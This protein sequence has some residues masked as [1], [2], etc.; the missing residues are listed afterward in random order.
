MLKHIAFPVENTGFASKTYVLLTENSGFGSKTYVFLRK[1]I[2]FVCPKTRKSYNPIFLKL[3]GRSCRPAG[4]H[5]GRSGEKAKEI[6]KDMVLGFYGFRVVGLGFEVE[7]LWFEGF[8]FWVLGVGSWGLTCKV[9]TGCG[10]G[11][12]RFQS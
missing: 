2:A 10:L 12:L 6:Q 1:T 4:R 7:G 11:L 8:G 5:P 3:F 9:L